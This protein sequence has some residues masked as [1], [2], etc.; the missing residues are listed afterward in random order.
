MVRRNGEMPSSCDMAYIHRPLPLLNSCN[1]TFSI[2]HAL[3]FN[4]GGLVTARHNKLCG[5]V[6]YL[7]SKAFTPTH[8]S[9]D[10]LIFVG[11]AVKRPKANPA[12]SKATKATSSMLPLEATEQKG[13]LLIYE[14][15]KNGT[16]NVHGMHI[17][18]T[19]AKS[20]SEKTPEKCLQE[21]EWAKKKMY[22]GACLQQRQ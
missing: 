2:C 4:W 5:R 19:Y 16:D 9:D 12:I 13:D 1:A 15:W 10:P 21:S 3:N 20:H 18:N 6:A 8:V 17:L 11:C 7:S 14:L 22:L